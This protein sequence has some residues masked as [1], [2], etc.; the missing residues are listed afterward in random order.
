VLKSHASCWNS[1]RACHNCTHT[2]P[3]SHSVCRNHTHRCHIHTQTCQNYSRVSENHTLRVKSHS[4]WKNLS[5]A[6]W[7]HTRACTFTAVE[8]TVHVEIILCVYESWSYRIYTRVFH[9]QTR[10]CQAYSL[11]CTKHTRRVKS[12][13][14]CGNLTLL[15][16]TNLLRVEITLMR[17][18]IT[19]CVFKSHSWVSYL[20]A[21]V[22]KLFSC[23]WK[24]HYACKITLCVWKSYFAYRNQ[25]CTCLNHTRAYWNHCV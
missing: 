10:T 19:L 25:S 8:I 18:K 4:A 2:C 1:T 9:I 20:H 6:F 5:P 16:E 12:H 14:A 15:L 24:P 11:V 21:Y 22:A 7:S 3:K 13:S 17:V 23:E